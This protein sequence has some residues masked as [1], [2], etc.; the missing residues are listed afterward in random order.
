MKLLGKTKDKIYFGRQPGWGKPVKVVMYDRQKPT[1]GQGEFTGHAM[2][3][4]EYRTWNEARESI[5]AVPDVEL[6]KNWRY[7]QM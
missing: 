4:G 2:W 3:L 6:S 5:R 7:A 1:K